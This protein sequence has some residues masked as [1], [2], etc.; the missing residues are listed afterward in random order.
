MTLKLKQLGFRH[1]ATSC[2]SSYRLNRVQCTKVNN[3]I[4]QPLANE[5]GVPQ[6]SILGP[7]LFICYANDMPFHLWYSRSFLYADDAA[8]I[9]NDMDTSN[10]TRYLQEDLNTLKRWFGANRLCLNVKKTKSMLFSSS[11]SANRNAVCSL[12][13]D[14]NLI[15]C[16]DSFKYLSVE[17]QTPKFWE[18]CNQSVNE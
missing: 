16:V 4:S 1:S 15:E 2:V 12:E 18:S 14:G 17:V 5:C 7:L 13:I 8:I 11:R 3:T 10:I 9:V 6:G